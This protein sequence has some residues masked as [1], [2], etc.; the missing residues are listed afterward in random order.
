MSQALV[1]IIARNHARARFVRARRAYRTA[2]ARR[3]LTARR[4]SR[5]QPRDLGS[6]AAL[7]W[8]TGRLRAIPLDSIVG[9]VDPTPDFDA[10]FRPTTDRVASR[11][12]SIAH[13]HLEGRF[14]P[15]IEVIERPDGYYV[16]DGRHRVSV[17]RALDRHDID[18]R[19]SPA[20]YVPRARPA[21]PSMN[22]DGPIPNLA[23][24]APAPGNPR[25]S[26]DST[27]HSTTSAS[28]CLRA[29]QPTSRPRTLTPSTR[30]ICAAAGPA[31]STSCARCASEAT[32][33]SLGLRASL[34][35]TPPP[36]DRGGTGSTDTAIAA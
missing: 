2:R 32:P 30:P 8:R 14:L 5:T 22:Q 31:W 1:A 35:S 21:K 23:V 29:T 13:A 12:E 11:W 15:P 25:P 7:T 33:K 18:A 34:R 27:S 28:R 26:V 16:L 6:T 24:A 4:P 20:P 9:T 3:M 17:A 19:T 36:A 10:E